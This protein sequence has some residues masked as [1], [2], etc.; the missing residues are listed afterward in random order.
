MD[1][2]LPTESEFV[3]PL[4]RPVRALLAHMQERKQ[5][6]GASCEDLEMEIQGATRIS[7][8]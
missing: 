2:K 8:R 7:P 3:S 4:L 1:E 5:P 6:E